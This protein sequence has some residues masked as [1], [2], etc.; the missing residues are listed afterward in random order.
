M[1]HSV[2]E[3]DREYIRNEGKT[4]LETK[5]PLK[6]ENICSNKPFTVRY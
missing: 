4:G 2:I 6:R 3:E 5:N 1:P